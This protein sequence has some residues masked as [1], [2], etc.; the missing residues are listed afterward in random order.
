[1]GA[2]AVGGG[3]EYIALSKPTSAISDNEAAE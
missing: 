2:G 3:L 1:M